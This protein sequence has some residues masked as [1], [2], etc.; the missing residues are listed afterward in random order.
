MHRQCPPTLWTTFFLSNGLRLKQYC[1]QVGMSASSLPLPHLTR[2]VLSS[3][4]FKLRQGAS[5]SPNVGLSVG[6][7]VEKNRKSKFFDYLINF[8]ALL[9]IGSMEGGWGWGD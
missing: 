5:I 6:L 3:G 7:S 8:A 4:L 1:Y 2:F 9:R